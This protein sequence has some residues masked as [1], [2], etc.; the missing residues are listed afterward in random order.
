VRSLEEKLNR[1]LAKLI[2]SGGLAPAKDEAKVT[3][4]RFWQEV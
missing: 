3:F 2:E 4:S 1:L